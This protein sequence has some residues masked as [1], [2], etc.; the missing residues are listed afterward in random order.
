[1]NRRRFLGAL[2]LLGGAPASRAEDAIAALPFSSLRPGAAL[3][4]WLQPYVF[5]NRPRTSYA[6]VAD[7][8]RTVLR[9]FADA[10]A[11]GLF[12]PME[13]D[14]RA[15]TIVAWRWKVTRLVEKGDLR[16]KAGDDYAARLYVGFDI[17][18]AALAVRERAKLELARAMSGV[19]VPA[20]S[21]CY[22]WDRHAPA[23]TFAPSAY[24]ESVHM[25]VAQSGTARLGTW[26]A[27]ERDL[28]ADFR[29]AFGPVQEL[30]K[31]CALIVATDT[32]DT[33]EQ[34]EAFYGDVELRARR[35]S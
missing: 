35:S 3:P 2:A 13:A 18:P 32:D 9:A 21:L 19:K 6:L 17:D 12:R 20:A 1:M 33:G 24:T 25:V 4:E 11:S 14:L 34:A 16:K 29:R 15:H 30:P 23:E 8:G 28:A 22:V 27:H 7:A 5:P 31:V 10:S 26:T